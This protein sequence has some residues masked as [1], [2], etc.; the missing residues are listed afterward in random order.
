MLWL[1]PIVSAVIAY[2]V[3][4]AVVY[5]LASSG[6]ITVNGQSQGILPVL[7]IGAGTDYALLLVA[8]YREELRRHA[9]R[10]EA[11]AFALHRAAP[12]ILA[13][14]ATVVLGMLCLLLRRAQL[15]PGPRAGARR[16]HR[17]HLPGDGHPAAGAA[18]GH[19]PLGLLAP[20]ARLRLRRA[21]R[22]GRLGPRGSSHRP[23]GRARCGSAPR[24]C[25][26][27]PASAPCSSTRRACPP[28]TPTPRSSTPSA[29]RRPWRRHGLADTSNTL[30]VVSTAESDAA[31]KQ[32]LSGVE[33][34]TVPPGAPPVVQ[35]GVAFNA[36]LID[37][38][39]SSQRRLRHGASA[40]AT[41]CTPCRVPR[42]WWA[43]A[44]RST[45]TPTRPP[46]G[47]TG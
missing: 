44:R 18:G 34:L 9:D 11:M 24:P 22:L 42:R 3:S 36:A 35:D 1:L 2:L 26:P 28:R 38:D 12:A 20:A 32:A 10:H 33:G 8:R 4:G 5:L 16:R 45:S 37:A 21:H 41:R 13:S 14:S 29:A 6:A 23:R 39:V 15:H 25:S 47:T 7:V 43:A 30:L 27:S 40:P 17:G 46:P 31:V 19:R